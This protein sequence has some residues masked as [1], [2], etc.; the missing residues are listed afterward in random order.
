MDV[1][2]S[3]AISAEQ[4]AFL[5]ELARQSVWTANDRLLQSGAL[6]RCAK[7]AQT[8]R[9]LSGHILHRAAPVRSIISFWSVMS[10]LQQTKTVKQ[11]DQGAC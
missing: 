11:Y 10:H 3:S 2:V 7:G 5:L 9:Q 6:R 8:D 1:N 4:P